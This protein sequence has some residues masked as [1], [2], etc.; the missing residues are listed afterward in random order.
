[1]SPLTQT[2]AVAT[3]LGDFVV[4]QIISQ[5]VILVVNVYKQQLVVL[6]WVRGTEFGL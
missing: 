6:V 4:T 2:S 3:S 5:N 1:M